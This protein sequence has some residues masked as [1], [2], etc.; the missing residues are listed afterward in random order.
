M[1]HSNVHQVKGKVNFIVNLKILFPR[2]TKK[3]H[4]NARTLNIYKKHKIT[5]PINR[6]TEHI[7]HKLVSNIYS[8]HTFQ[9]VALIIQYMSSYSRQISVGKVTKYIELSTIK[10]YLYFT[11]VFSFYATIYLYST[12][13]W[14]QILYFTNLH[15]FDG[16]IFLCRLILLIQM[17]NELMNYN[18]RPKLHWICLAL[19]LMLKDTLH[20]IRNSTKSI[21]H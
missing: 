1:V 10:R 8:S 20:Q 14:E 2:Y 19:F 12:K 5:N 17:L 16:Y 13:T 11:W 7:I 15:L 18:G 9:T 4:S 6:L 21:N 3:T